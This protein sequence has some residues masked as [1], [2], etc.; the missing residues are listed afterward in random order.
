MFIIHKFIKQLNT[1]SKITLYLQKN[2]TL[3]MI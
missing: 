1:Y 3:E 2:K